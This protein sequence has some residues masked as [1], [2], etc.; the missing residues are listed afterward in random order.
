[1]ARRVDRESGAYKC[2]D[3]SGGKSQGMPIKADDST[4]SFKEDLSP[5]SQIPKVYFSAKILK[6][7]TASLSLGPE[8]A[9]VLKG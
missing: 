4:F 2:P 5:A 1:M 7:E 3:P 9:L 6:G 8:R